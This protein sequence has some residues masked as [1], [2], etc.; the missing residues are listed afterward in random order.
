M[1]NQP[2]RLRSDPRSHPDAGMSTSEDPILPTP[3]PH[4]RPRCAW[5]P[6]TRQAQQERQWLQREIQKLTPHSQ[7]SHPGIQFT[8]HAYQLLVHRA[9]VLLHQVE[10]LFHEESDGLECTV[11]MQTHRADHA[12]EV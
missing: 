3:D 8:P 11:G 5:T 10:E 2:T 6:T 7:V 9:R 4:I 12:D 1:A